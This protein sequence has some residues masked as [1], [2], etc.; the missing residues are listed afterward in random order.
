MA[1]LSSSSAS[2]TQRWLSWGLKSFVFGTAVMT[3]VHYFPMIQDSTMKNAVSLATEQHSMFALEGVRRLRRQARQSDMRRHGLL[4]H[5]ALSV[6]VNAVSH[7]DARVRDVALEALAIF[8]HGAVRDAQAQNHD[9]PHVAAARILQFPAV[10]KALVDGDA[11]P[12]EEDE[13]G[14]GLADSR[15]GKGCHALWDVVFQQRVQQLQQMEQSAVR[16]PE[17]KTERVEWLRQLVEEQ[18][19][20]K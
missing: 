13:D 20:E 15:C 11:G 17:S 10:A 3:G 7:R 1:G 14:G 6:L 19:K 12:K 9:M 8:A 5:G 4:K 18:D 2:G 16:R